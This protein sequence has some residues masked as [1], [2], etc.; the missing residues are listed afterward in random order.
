[1]RLFSYINLT[2]NNFPCL[3]LSNSLKDVSKDHDINKG[4]CFKDSTWM[5]CVR[6][7]LRHMNYAEGPMW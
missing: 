3:K 2:L 6:W 4:W 5:M 7:D 1:M